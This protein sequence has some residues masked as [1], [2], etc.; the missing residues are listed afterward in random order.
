MQQ[1]VMF[2]ITYFARS[3]AATLPGGVGATQTVFAELIRFCCLVALYPLNSSKV[4]S[5]CK[6]PFILKT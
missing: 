6:G 3:D 5:R 1:R 4:K 2:N